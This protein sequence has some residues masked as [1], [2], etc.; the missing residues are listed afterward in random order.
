[1]D[2]IFAGTGEVKELKW[3]GPA[4]PIEVDEEYKYRGDEE[5]FRGIHTEAN[6]VDVSDSSMTEDCAKTPQLTDSSR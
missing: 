4:H 5:E 3:E 6:P 1:M 2:H